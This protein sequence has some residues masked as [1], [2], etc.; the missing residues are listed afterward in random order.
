[1]KYRAFTLTVEESR[2]PMNFATVERLDRRT[3]SVAPFPATKGNAERLIR[4]AAPNPTKNF[5][6]EMMY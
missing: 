5:K 2:V 3:I 1:M 6:V 4:F